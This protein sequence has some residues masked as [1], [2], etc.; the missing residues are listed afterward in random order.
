MNTFPSKKH[1]VAACAA[2]L[3]LVVTGCQSVNAW[4]AGAGPS[5]KIIENQGR[6]I[7]TVNEDGSV[8]EQVS[9]LTV[10]EIDSR[11]AALSSR[12]SPVSRFSDH[13]QSVQNFN[14]RISAGDVV[15]VSIWEAPPALLFGTANDISGLTGSKEVKLPEQMVDARGQISI[16]FVGK[17]VVM[18][19][20]P[21]E[22]Q[23]MIVRGL[24]R[25]A[26]SPSAVVRIAKNNSADVT[27]LGEVNNSTRMPLTGKAER[28][29]DAVAA[30]GGAKHPSSRVTIQLNRQGQSV[31]MPFDMVVN[32]PRQNI[33]LQTGDVVSVNYQSK[34]FTVMGA[35][36]RNDEINFEA[37]GISLM[38]ALA[39]AGGLNDNRADARGVFIFRY[40]NINMLSPEQ[41]Q[42]LPDELKSSRIVPIV[43]RMNLRD[44]VSYMTAQNFPIK[45][46]D[47]IYVSNAPGADFAKFMA[48]IGQGVGLV[49]AV[50]DLSNN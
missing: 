14:N 1:L 42:A 37:S 20:T 46:K 13:Y 15:D 3:S 34:S 16:P 29:L 25:K 41:Y 8:E 50:N 47:V 35:T 24:H 7:T 10:V 32:D 22:V 28:V 4:Q 45:D 9:G 12:L 30:A 40:D 17:L 26:N 2:A 43:Y 44:P 19:K 38:Q 5:K 39:R 48:L 6:T 11:I 31:E 23:D 21:Q 27:V 33:I 18:G 36:A 49:N